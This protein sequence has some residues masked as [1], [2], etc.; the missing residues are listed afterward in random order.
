ML[1]WASEIIGLVD[2][3]KDNRYEAIWSQYLNKD[4]NCSWVVFVE[5]HVVECAI[6]WNIDAYLDS[7]LKI[8]ADWQRGILGT[9]EII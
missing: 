1:A 8:V 9:I 6:K 3:A 5:V 4:L 7:D 2:E